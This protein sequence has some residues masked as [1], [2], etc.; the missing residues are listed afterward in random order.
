MS[1]RNSII[2]FSVPESAAAVSQNSFVL[3][4]PSCRFTLMASSSSLNTC[5]AWWRVLRWRCRKRS[6]SAQRLPQVSHR[7][8]ASVSPSSWLSHVG[9]SCA[10]PPPQSPLLSPSTWSRSST[11][12]AA[13]ASH[14][15]GLRIP[16]SG[17]RWSAPSLVRLRTASATALLAM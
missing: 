11:Q 10:A 15:L 17:L 1:S 9:R 4:Q 2:P 12:S 16:S 13:T 7:M 3:P 5:L 8:M 6:Q 14:T